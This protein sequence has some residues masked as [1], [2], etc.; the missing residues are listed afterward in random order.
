MDRS[1]GETR[2]LNTSSHAQYELGSEALYQKL[3]EANRLEVAH[4]E[5]QIVLKFC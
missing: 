1:Y 3:R 2:G 4:R 5:Y